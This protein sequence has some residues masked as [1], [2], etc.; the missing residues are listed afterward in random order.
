VISWARLPLAL[1]PVIAAG[2]VAFRRG[3]L[4]VAGPAQTSRS[5]PLSV[6]P[7][8]VHPHRRVPWRALRGL[9]L[10]A[11]TLAILAYAAHLAKTLNGLYPISE[12]LFWRYARCWAW[13]LFFVCACLSSGHF[14]LSRIRA[15][16]LSIPEHGLMSFGIGMLVFS[17]GMFL[18]GVLHLYGP[19]W[20]VVWPMALVLLGAP[21]IVRYARETVLPAWR[22]AIR[23]G[24]P[25]AT[26]FEI[27]VHG[28]GIIG[29]SLIY[30]PILTPENTAYDASWYHL[31]IAEHYAAQGGV[32]AMPEGAYNPALPHLASFLYTWA[33][34]VPWGDL[35]D[36][37]ELSAHLEFVVFLFTAFSIPLLV[38]W[39]AP[40]SRAR[41]AWVAMF[42]FPGIFVYD[43]S[44]STAAD[45]IT[46]FWAIPIW[47]TLYRALD[48]MRPRAFV[49]A[50]VMMAGAI[51]TKYQAL[52]LLLFPAWAV[53]FRVVHLL[54]ERPRRFSVRAVLV[55]PSVLV[56]TMLVLTTPHWLANSIWHHNP[57]YPFL[58]RL[59]P[60]RPFTPDA[61][62][63][64]DSYYVHTQL[65]HPTGTLFENLRQ[66]I[67]VVFT[68]ALTP[69]DW[70]ER[71]TV[72]GFLLTAALVCAP[73]V[74]RAR[75]LWPILIAAHM[76]VFAWFMGSHQARY[77]QIMLPW[78]AAATAGFM[79]LV[80][81]AHLVPRIAL[82]VLLSLQIIW[83]GDIPFFDHWMMMSAPIKKVADV[84]SSG[85]RKDF[86]W[87]HQVF[88]D[89][90]RVGETLP[91]GAKVLV[92]DLQMHLGL[93]AMSVMDAKAWQGGIAYGAMRSPRALYDQ[94]RS[95]NVTDVLWQAGLS[96]GLDSYAGEFAFHEFAERYCVP[97][98]TF[99]SLVIAKVPETPP[100]DRSWFDEQA[101]VLLGA[102][103]GTY[104]RGVYPIRDLT[105]LEAG[106][107]ESRPRPLQAIDDT[108][109]LEAA[110]QRAAFIVYGRN[111]TLSLPSNLDATFT[112]V[113][114][115]AQVRMWVRRN[116]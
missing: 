57:V 77:L 40:G 33:F 80:W 51:M 47:L 25:R 110:L 7:R 72:F 5:R 116:P 64:F 12:W 106:K 81:H 56:L 35:F 58:H 6:P 96:V 91:R 29:L 98:R 93:Q 114:S 14:V 32:A 43:S 78:F 53:A 55:G 30:L 112:S 67:R 37:V 84:I 70:G 75:R 103:S 69:E 27:L 11:L 108:A 18:G 26:L 2:R 104:R 107:P 102:T 3:I 31:A 95:W 8:K 50:A 71:T 90:G 46:A 34:L 89:M 105:I 60:S 87:Q 41:A 66:A 13:A 36:R 49:L 88:G 15:Y 97:K 111:E 19:S 113:V 39:I 61:Q 86:D 115:N 79:A 42:L 54:V 99:G 85:H 10:V 9:P 59:F 62:N 100:A 92:H 16:C 94:L 20:F 21:S 109:T 65:T 22:D 1:G 101:I 74:P 76:G 52:L 44:L 28:F 68:F 63:L 23:D 73:F 24:W 45:H 38:R 48:T 83:G 82:V 17:T 4:L